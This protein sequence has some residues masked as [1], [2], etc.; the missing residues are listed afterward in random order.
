MTRMGLQQVE[1][2]AAPADGTSQF[3]YWTEPLAWDAKEARL[4][5]VDPALPQAERTLADFQ[6]DPV[7]IVHVERVNS[8]GRRQAELV[9][10]KDANPE[11]MAKLDLR[12]KLVLTPDKRPT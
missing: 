1:M 3:G 10:L 4:D 12:G 11:T 9:D 6:K 5:I 7:L 8:P 2:L